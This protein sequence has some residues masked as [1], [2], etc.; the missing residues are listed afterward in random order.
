[1]Q[2]PE[3]L[4]GLD[5][6]LD[7]K[8]HHINMRVPEVAEVI[9][10]VMPPEIRSPSLVDASLALELQYIIDT[11]DDEAPEESQAKAFVKSP[12]SL[13]AVLH[14]RNALYNFLANEGRALAYRPSCPDTPV[15][16]DL[17]FYWLALRLPAWDFFEPGVVITPHRSLLNCRRA[18][19]RKSRRA[20]SAWV[21]LSIGPAVRRHA[22]F[23]ADAP[24]GSRHR[25]G[26]APLG[27]GRP[28]SP[29]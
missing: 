15:E 4:A 14:V 2:I 13:A 21:S 10:L 25:G 1:M 5:L 3:N 26:V 27:S 12:E 17:L 7:G 28:R 19:V 6:T 18:H 20:P 16:L 22:G 23:P 24:G 8:R 11:I 29:R 9:S